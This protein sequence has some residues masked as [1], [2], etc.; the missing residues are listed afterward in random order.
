MIVRL[1]T[2]GQ[3]VIPKRL[4]NVLGL[5]PGTYL[6]ARIEGNKIVLEPLGGDSPIE[7]LH[8]HYTD[9]DFLTLLETEHQGELYER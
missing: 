2:K 5:R 9:E 8:G 1:S 3:L 7:A 4:R 6:D